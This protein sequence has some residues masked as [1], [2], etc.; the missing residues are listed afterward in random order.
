MKSIA[1]KV[2]G[3]VMLKIRVVKAMLRVTAAAAISLLVAVSASAQTVRYVHTDG[4]GSVV[5]VTDKDRNIVERREY[6]PYGG[7]LNRSVADGPGYT[8]HV[9]DAATGLTYMQQRYFDSSIGRLLSVDPISA[10]EKP[11]A[12]FNRYY[13]ANNNPYRFVDYDGRLSIA[14]GASGNASALGGITA[15]TQWVYSFPSLNP[16]T[17]SIGVLGQGGGMAGT[18]IGVG[19]AGAV[20][21]NT[22]A[23]SA[24]DMAGAG[25]SASAGGSANMY[26]LAFCYDHDLGGPNQTISIGQQLKLLPFENHTSVTASY[27]K[28]IFTGADVA[29]VVKGMVS[30]GDKTPSVEVGPLEVVPLP[31]VSMPAPVAPNT[32]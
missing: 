26:F 12:N 27:G 31:P 17:W 9:M 28:T 14:T 21:W 19:Y 25:L 5:L 4:L 24:E 8:G 30:G 22:S 7:L 23:N 6:E 16:M 15:S 11:L 10:Y 18:D 2:Q 32:K 29:S 1:Q 13:Y 3:R 20:T